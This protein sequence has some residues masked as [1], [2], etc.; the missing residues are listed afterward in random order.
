MP[1]VFKTGELLI[2]EATAVEFFLDD[3]VGQ[4]L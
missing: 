1:G 2:F 4:K 3:Q